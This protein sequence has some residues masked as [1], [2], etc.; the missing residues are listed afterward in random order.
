MSVERVP[1]GLTRPPADDAGE[2]ELVELI[3]S[4]IERDAPVTFARFMEL[5]LYAPGLGYYATSANRTTRAGDFLT[6]PELH[7]IFGWT[8]AAQVEE[9][10]ARLGQPAPFVLREYGAGT[11]AL[12]RHIG[13][14][15]ESSGSPLAP[16]IRYEPIEIEGRLEPPRGS[17]AMVG[18]VI[19]N[20]FLDALPVHR[21]RN[22]SGVLHEL[23]VG[24]SS[25]RFVEVIEDV[26]DS[27]LTDR[28]IVGEGGLPDGHATEVSLATVGWLA[29]VH[30]ELERGYVLIVDYGLSE[31]E[32]YSPVR[33]NG[34]LR[35]FRAQHVSSDVL[36][37]VG[38]QD[39]TATVN[40]DGLT[41][42]AQ[43]CGFELL[44]RTTA[45]RFLLGSGLDTV[46]REA[47][48]VADLE[49]ESAA[50]LRSAVRRLLD[51]GQL[52]GYAVLLLGKDV[53]SEPVLRG[54]A[55]HLN[56]AS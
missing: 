39:I 43:A 21:V 17:R 10:W 35:A 52:G 12:G 5:A 19:A 41:R 27:R 29:N 28:V 50:L 33:A 30:S 26:S 14:R 20:E 18:C 37:G 31:A 40:L 1:S 25:G 8:L 49:W 44:G 13:E 24:W 42:D 11:G 48:E 6:A 34:T 23:R 56:P 15:L 46:Y 9:M 16:H 4:E 53:P 54:F 22:D 38:R 2:P 36:S 3:R 51:P 45:A 47:R 55:P 32:L 7:P